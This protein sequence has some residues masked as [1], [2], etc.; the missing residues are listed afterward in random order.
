[1]F[2][3]LAE[4]VTIGKDVEAMYPPTESYQGKTLLVR[5]EEQ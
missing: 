4:S 2:G 3:S 5:I 1:V